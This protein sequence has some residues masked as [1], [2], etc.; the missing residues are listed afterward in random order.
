MNTKLKINL[1]KFCY[2]IIHWI[3]AI[4]NKNDQVVIKRQNIIWDLDLSEGIDFSIYILGAFEKATVNR[5][6]DIVKEGDI[7]FDIGA[8]CGSHTLPLAK[9]VGSKGKVFAFEPT[10]Y[11][12]KK[13]RRNIELNEELK[14]RI[15]PLQVMIADHTMTHLVPEI[16]SSWPLKNKDALHPD[17]F[18]ALKTTKGS[19]IETVDGFVKK[20]KLKKLDFIKLDVDGNEF[21][22]LSGSQDTLARFKPKILLE[23]APSCHSKEQ[24]KGF[25]QILQNNK[26][27]GLSIK[28]LKPLSLDYATLTQNIKFGSS[29]NVLLQIP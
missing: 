16:Y 6:T 8:N 23:I 19:S 25:L 24:F 29:I 4:V 7:V 14:S 11:A 15:N 27:E 28:T 10:D 5:Y 22:V 26:Y 1:A 3:R 18:G 9:L 21:S 20:H 13:L 2:Q 12:Y 17:H